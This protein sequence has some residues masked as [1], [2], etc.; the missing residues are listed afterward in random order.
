[1]PITNRVKITTKKTSGLRSLPKSQAGNCSVKLVDVFYEINK[2]FEDLE[3]RLISAVT[4]LTSAEAAIKK[5]TPLS[6]LIEPSS[7]PSL[8]DLAGASRFIDSVSSESLRR[9][10]NSKNAII[11]N[12]PD[13]QP[14]EKVKQTL[15][16][17]CNMAHYPSHCVRLRKK[18]QQKSCPLLIQFQD[19]KVAREFI[20]KKDTIA[21]NTLYKTIR[22][23]EDKT[24]LQREVL[25][26]QKG[27]PSLPP[28]VEAIRSSCSPSNPQNLDLGTPSP[29]NSLKC[30]VDLDKSPC[31]PPFNHHERKCISNHPRRDANPHCNS[32][33]SLL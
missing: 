33:K 5:L 13:R 21:I 16:N 8:H 3:K 22:I 26:L 18:T 32:Q 20:R 7:S 1:M 6:H 10:Q 31:T 9:I 12:I 17:A 14:L 29:K 30:E 19:G 28:R 25:G 15:L 23:T 27:A 4:Q 24:P 11:F 2:R